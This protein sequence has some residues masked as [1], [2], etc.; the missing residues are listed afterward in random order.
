RDLMAAYQ[1]L[2]ERRLPA[3]SPAPDFALYLKWLDRRDYQASRA[4]WTN[5][6]A[7]CP[8]ATG[9][10]GV[11][12]DTPGA[13]YALGEH[14]FVFH[15]ETSAALSRLAVRLQVTLNA[16]LQTLWA[17]LLARYNGTDDVLFGA[18]VS[19][20]PPDLV[21]IEDMVGLFLQSIPVRIRVAP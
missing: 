16:L 5:Y 11:Q 1:A 3:L 6:L 7:D 18:V 2:T 21:G 17:V 14:V 15:A 20:R 4:Y 10:P 8:A 13:G 19:G 12:L 9:V